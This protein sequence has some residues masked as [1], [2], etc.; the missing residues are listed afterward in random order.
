MGNKAREVSGDQTV[1]AVNATPGE[2]ALLTR[3]E[4][5]IL[6]KWLEKGKGQLNMVTA[7]PWEIKGSIKK[8]FPG[9]VLRYLE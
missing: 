1:A 9:L 7:W 3:Q 4:G 2:L 8:L 6:R 5:R